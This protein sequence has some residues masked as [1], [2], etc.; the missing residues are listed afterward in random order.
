MKKHINLLTSRDDNKRRIRIEKL[1]R[2]SVIVVGLIVFVSIG[3]L[4][5]LNARETNKLNTLIAQKKQYLQQQIAMARLRSQAVTVAGRVQTAQAVIG[6]QPSFLKYLSDLNTFIPSSSE[7]RLLALSVDSKSDGTVQ[8]E[9]SSEAA[10]QSF[11]DALEAD[12]SDKLFRKIV[13]QDLSTNFE[14]QKALT[15]V[16]LGIE[17]YGKKTA[18]IGIK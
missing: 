7:A 13:V 10:V 4:F 3:S 16:T 14:N 9:F 1:M 11:L 12:S 2:N 17:F 5:L 8:L 15:L 6:D 18:T